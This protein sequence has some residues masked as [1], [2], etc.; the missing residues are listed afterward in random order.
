MKEETKSAGRIDGDKSWGSGE[1]DNGLTQTRCPVG[2]RS[3]WVPL[4]S[5]TLASA[6]G[7]ARARATSGF[8]KGLL[9]W[10]SLRPLEVVS[11][12]STT[13]GCAWAPVP[14]FALSSHEARW[15]SEQIAEITVSRI[16]CLPPWRPLLSAVWKPTPL[17]LHGHLPLPPFSLLQTWPFMVAG[18]PESDLKEVVTASRLCGTTA[19]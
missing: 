14:L 16:H 4:L 7:Y 11:S 5:L 12:C 19:S 2:E 9:S 1:A 10:V 13:R 3:F 18:K 8:P 6:S 17:L 15:D